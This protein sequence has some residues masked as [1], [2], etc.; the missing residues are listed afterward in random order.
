MATFVST[1][2][3][4]EMGTGYDLFIC[5]RA[6]HNPDRF[7]LRPSWA[8]GVR[9]RL[10]LEQ[11]KVLE[12]SD[13]ILRGSIRFVFGLPNPKGAA[14]V[15]QGLEALPVDKRLEALSFDANGPEE[16]RQLLLS[17]TSGRKWSAAEKE[18]I[19]LNS[20]YRDQELL[21]AYAD[22]LFDAWA[23]RE[24]FGE[25][26]LAALK[27]FVDGFFAEEENRILPVLKRGLSHAQMRAGSLPLPAMLEELSSGVRYGDLSKISRLFLAPSFWGAPILFVEELGPGSVLMLFGYRPE[28]MALIPGEVIPDALIHGLK[29]LADPTR[30]RILRNLAQSPA[31]AAQISQVLRLR[32]PTV[33]HHL[34]ELRMAGLVQVIVNPEGE[35]HYATRY[36]GLST[37][38]ELM[39][40]FIQGE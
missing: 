19:R 12:D 36:E 17:T 16:Y 7:G 40:Q 22:H 35:R 39:R 5:L 3:N 31:T 2:L 30:L 6:L 21:P 13:G 24:Q 38:K 34:S 33:T 15:V 9:S 37:V 23:N 10:S 1:K 25:V 32:L 29:A 8:A 20:R 18:I 14:E 11:R 27:S 26:Y 28:N 4:W